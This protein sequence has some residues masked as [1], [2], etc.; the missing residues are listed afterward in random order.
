MESDGRKATFLREA[1]RV[2]GAQGVSIRN[3]RIETLSDKAA[4]VITA[5]ACAPLG[6]LLAYAE[7][8]LAPR[9]ICLF[10]KGQGADAELTALGEERKIAVERFPSATSSDG[11]I[12]R[13][14]GIEA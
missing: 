4:D 3:Q 11:V 12:L 9:G 6:R 8:L 7:P 10:L 1:I 14:G 13:I 5:R 2:T